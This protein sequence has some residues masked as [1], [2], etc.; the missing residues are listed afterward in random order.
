MPGWRPCSTPRRDRARCWAPPAVRASARPRPRRRVDVALWAA[1]GRTA[2]LAGRVPAAAGLGEQPQD[3][4]SPLPASTCTSCSPPPRCSLLLSPPLRL[5]RRVPLAPCLHPS[6]R[7]HLCRAPA[8]VARLLQ[9]CNV[10][11]R[12]TQEVVAGGVAGLA[13]VALGGT[14]TRRQRPTGR[15]A[16]YPAPPS[17]RRVRGA[18]QGAWWEQP[19]ARW[20]GRARALAHSE[21]RRAR[22]GQRS[23]LALAAAAAFAFSALGRPAPPGSLARSRMGRPG[24]PT[25]R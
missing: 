9:H 16:L 25:P 15:G 23:S 6:L 8:R 11:A 12:N 4:S 10:V 14:R 22:G 1:A 18:R 24:R 13:R 7:F 20:R 5:A 17:T 19:R 2:P 21:P 3:T